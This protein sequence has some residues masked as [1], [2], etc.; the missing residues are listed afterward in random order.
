MDGARVAVR[1]H[2]LGQVGR[3]VVRRAHVGDRHAR[4]DPVPG[5]GGRGRHEAH[6]RWVPAGQASALPPRGVQHHVLLL[7]QVGRRPARLRRDARAARQAA[8]RRD[9]LHTAGQVP[10]QRLLQHHHLH[11]WRAPVTTEAA[12]VAT[13]H[14]P[15]PVRVIVITLLLC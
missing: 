3:V 13:L 11:K 1:Q 4:L 7:G 14:Y 8:R 10:G 12:T 2:V 15:L 6:P 9:R 5:H